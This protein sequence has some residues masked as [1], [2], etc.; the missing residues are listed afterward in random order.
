MQG[1]AADDCRSQSAEDMED[2]GKE[3]PGDFPEERNEKEESGNQF[4]CGQS[5]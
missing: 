1:L 3:E 2:T 5:V 4:N